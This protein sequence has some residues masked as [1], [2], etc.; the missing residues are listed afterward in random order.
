VLVM[1]LVT[2]GMLCCG[3]CG[4]W[5]P[6]APQRP[7]T[8]KDLLLDQDA[9]P[10]AW[11]DTWGPFLPAGHDL[12]TTECSAVQFG[13]AAQDLPIRAEQDVYRYL[14]TDIAQRIFEEVYLP[15]R[16]HLSSISDR[17]YQSLIA[18]RQYFGCYDVEGRDT[19]IC[20]W[21]GQYEEYIVVLWCRMISGEMS[22][23]DMERAVR[24]IDAR[25]EHYLNEPTGEGN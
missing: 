21:A 25:M 18:N 1:L 14:S 20:E 4:F 8:L 23:A 3:R 6:R 15:Q 11:E 2:I 19:L 12:C 10:S 22:L 16:K 7:F 13:V 17:T 5:K 24:A 9:M